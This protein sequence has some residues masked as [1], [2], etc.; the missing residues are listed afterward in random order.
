MKSILD[1]NHLTINLFRS[2][3][4]PKHIGISAI[5]LILGVFY[6]KPVQAQTCV[7]DT[8]ILAS[9][10]PFADCPPGTDT[11]IIQ[12]TFYM[13]TSYEPIF[14][15][16]PFNGIILVDGGVINWN[17]P[18]DFRLG[19]AA[20][21]ILINGGM[22][23][24]AN[25]GDPGCS[26][27]KRLFFGTGPGSFQATC[28]GAPA[29]QAFSDINQ[30]GCISQ[31]GICCNAYIS[32]EETSG[33]DN[34]LTLC[35]PGDSA[36]IQVAGSGSLTYQYLWSPNLGSE[37]GPYDIAPNSTTNYFVNISA[38]FDP[39]V[40]DPY[41]LTC[42]GSV[43][44]R[45]NPQINL[46]A[47]TTSVPCAASETGAIDLMVSGGTSPYTYTWSNGSSTQDLSGL[48]AGTYT[49][50][51]VDARGC[52]E[53]LEV[54]IITIDLSPPILSCPSN[55]LDTALVDL[56]YTTVPGIDA[57]FTDDC[58]SPDLS[59]QLTGATVQ[60][61]SGNVSDVVQFNVGT[62]TVQYNVDD[63]TNVST[64][65]FTVIVRDIQLPTA[66][67][68]ADINDIQCI[69]DV[70][71]PNPAVVLDEADNC[72][73]PTVTFFNQSVIG[74]AG[75][76]GNPFLVIRRYRVTDQSGNTVTVSHTISVA[77]T[78]PPQFSLIPA[79]VTVNCDGI[80]P[81]GS[82]DAMDNCVEVVP[83]VY[84]GET[85]IDGP[86]PYTYT[87][88]RMWTASDN[89]GNTNT[90]VQTITV[91]DIVAPNFTFIPADVTVSCESIPGIGTPTATDNCDPNVNLVYNGEVRTDGACLDSYT[92]SR[93]W[94]ATDACG[95]VQTAV[96]VITV[97]DVSD[98]VFDFVP[99]N[100]T[101]ECDAIP[102]VGTPTATDNCDG[103]VEIT[104]NGEVRTD[105]SCL[106]N[107]T[108]TRTWTATDNCGNTQTASQVITV[109]DT[110][111]PSFLSVPADVTVNCDAIPAVGTATAEDNCD[112]NVSVV[113]NG[114][115]RT[116]GSCINTYTLNRSWTATDACGNQTTVSQNIEVQDTTAPVFTSFP[117]DV[118][119]D[120]DA[121]PG[122]A[123]PSADDNC[124]STVS[125]VY[126]GEFRTDGA[127]S[128][129]YT[130]SRQWTAT[131]ECGN[132]TT[133]VQTITVQDTTAPQF[134]LIPVSITVNCDAV[135]PIGTPTASDNCTASPVIVYNGQVRVDGACPDNYTLT[136]TWTVSD[137][138]GNTATAEQVITV[139]DV[140]NPTFLFVPADLTVNCES[141]PAVGTPI[142]SDNCT[143]NV[144]IEYN[145]ET[146]VDGACEDTYTLV[147]MWTAT[148]A[149]GNFTTAQQI[150]EVLDTISPIFLDIPADVTVSC[151]DIPAVVN[152]NPIDNCDIDVDLVYDGE[153]RVD[154]SCEDSYQLT[155]QWT[156]TDNCGNQNTLQQV[157]TVKD[158][159]A[160]IFLFVPTNI[161]INCDDVPTNG[162][163]QVID[164][165]DVDVTVVFDGEIRIDGD[166]PNNYTLDRIWIATD[167]C[168]NSTTAVQTLTVQ[169]TTPPIFT[170]VPGDTLVNC[171]AVPVAGMP[172]ASDNCTNVVD[173]V[174]DGE[175]RTDGSCPNA[176]TLVR[177]W[178]AT[179]EC[180]NNVSTS[181]L[182]Q[183]QDTTAPV[184]T[185]IAAD[186]L[187]NCD[188]VPD[189]E[190]AMA[191]DNCTSDVVVVY[192]GE[193]RTDGACPNEYTLERSWTAT[194]ECGNTS[195][196]I[197]TISVQDTTLPVFMFVPADILVDCE[198]V[199]TPGTPT[200]SDNCDANVTITYNGEQL[201]TGSCKDNYTLLRSWTATDAC[202]N[203][204]TASQL[205]T[206]QDTTKPVF[207]F[208][209]ADTLVNCDAIP[210]PGMP[211]A[212]DNC[213]DV[214]NILFVGETIAPG[215][216][217]NAYSITRRW[218]AT[219]DCGN[220]SMAQ[221]VL[222]VQDTTLPV[223]T[224]VPVDTLVNCHEIPVVGAPVAVDNC[225][226]DVTIDYLG[227]TRI[228]GACTDSYTLNRSWLATDNCGNTTLAVQVINVQD[229]TAPDFTFVPADTL[230]DCDAVPAPGTPTAGDN[231]DGDVQ[232]VYNGE[233]RTDGACEDAY[234]LTR[235]WTATD[236]CGNSSIATQLITVQDTTAPILL[237][238]PMDT[239]VNCDA[240]PDP[241]MP[242]ATDNCDGDVLVQYL[243][244]LITSGPCDDSYTLS[245]TWSATDNCGNISTAVQVVTVQDTMPPLFTSSPADTLVN[246]DA[247]P[248]VG[249][250][251]ASD[252]CDGDVQIDY[253]GETIMSSMNLETYTL[254]RKWTAT[255][256]CG[257]TSEITQVITVQDTIAP[258]IICP[259]DIA[260]LADAS[261]CAAIV[262]FD[263]PQTDDNC[264]TSLTLISSSLS[265]DTF[266]IGVNEV[267]MQISDPSGNTADCSFYITVQDTTAPVLVNCP[268]DMTFVSPDSNCM[269]VADWEPPLVIDPC[270]DYLI[271][272][273]PDI[274]PMSVFPTGHTVVTYTATDTTGNQLT[275]SFTVTVT[276]TIP[277]VLVDCPV[278]MT[279]YTDTCT[280]VATW[281]P[282]LATDNCDF[283]TLTS[284]FQSGD[285][286]PEGTTTVEYI[287]ADLWGNT[288][289]CTFD[290]TV[291][292]T[293]APT[294]S[295][296]P[297]DTIVDGLGACEIPVFWDQP[298]ATDNCVPD[299]LIYSIP[300][301]GDTFPVGHT[302]VSIFVEDPSGNTDT[303]IFVVTV[304]G[305]DLGFDDTPADQS[306]IGCEA[307]AT[308][309][310]PTPTGICGPYTITSTHEPGDTFPIGVTTVIYTLQDT[311]GYEATTSFTISV[312]E[313]NAPVIDC[314]TAPIV[315][316][317]SGAII[318]DASGFLTATDTV[319]TCDGVEL[320]F[321]LPIATDDC[322]PPVVSQI[323]GIDSGG[324]FVIGPHL[325]E[326]QAIDSAGNTALCPVQIEVLPLYPLAPMVSDTIGCPGD[327]ITLSTPV[328]T[329]AEY[330]WEGPYSDLPDANTILIMGLEDQYTGWYR[331]R[332]LVNG[333]YTPYDSAYV[334]MAIDPEAVDDLDF[335]I[336]PGGL[337]TG[338]DVLVNDTYDWDDFVVTLET[339]I[340]G[341]TDLG[342]GQFEYRAQL[343][344]G[345]VN[346]IYKLCSATCPNLCDR[347]E[348]VIN[349]RETICSYIPN[350]ITPNDDGYNDYLEIPCLETELYPN[351]SIV[352]YNQWGGKVYEASPYSNDP[353][354]AWRGT[355]MGEPGKDLP[356]AT[357]FYIFKSAPDA[358]AL[359]GYIEIFR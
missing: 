247:L 278:D 269:A 336:E 106:Y 126:D 259:D 57:S 262:A 26:P 63:G 325:V 306:F 110:N 89:C 353:G 62:T 263:P 25:V 82:P 107:Y 156:A 323:S 209:P 279:L 121:I 310:P 100:T 54:E 133:A 140:T 308:W 52:S 50:T 70:P 271:V 87:L 266:P 226:G 261:L 17:Q 305:P 224:F 165:C 13:N 104:Y 167:N 267:Y 324:Y 250:P 38:T 351:N 163:P 291:I 5:L 237:N 231:C 330:L 223:F 93:S 30:A 4:Y 228:D 192:N 280:S 358:E 350:I 14:N 60:S 176:Y 341:L 168:G 197:Q 225:D 203:A 159:I 15:G 201:T 284:N 185:F 41:L 246:C 186:T 73:T 99:A 253:N 242:T 129:A 357:Y 320:S 74:G 123:S 274:P 207:T 119:V 204:V 61:G 258:M 200:A 202:G 221:Q 96:Q 53:M 189:P 11:I 115:T 337:L 166:C 326:F 252:N 343:N 29:P 205:V 214:V 49:V 294:F 302:P 286:F 105:G 191:N 10:N 111:N 144:D 42:N 206:V 254:Q 249:M 47:N 65:S 158:T 329:G 217:Q 36:I 315:V 239:L 345:Y 108:L 287:A 265:G 313:N 147:R 150:V 347:A 51:V 316:D 3:F 97:Q 145:G 270:D 339:P 327:D 235:T 234:T 297:Q 33:N 86:C 46:S 43:T 27:I 255:D 334:R 187:V 233:V 314:P 37:P 307:I 236:N 181:Q 211:T 90:A 318:A 72:G 19:D 300:A 8:V 132:Q 292:D 131:D 16:V 35:S 136:R 101:V 130:L 293:V 139:Q 346:F 312:T 77:D 183:V 169:D 157:I 338:I 141:I 272:A 322:H 21:L 282:P 182:I 333:C 45:I 230:V 256:N 296:C 12:D 238:V 142:A 55:V 281:M 241:G 83:I 352:I 321:D 22:V 67:N 227:E 220:T 299:P 18:A 177:S 295:G 219:D 20:R 32:V 251:T 120:C 240:V 23:L 288:S 344:N 161:T 208:I 216:C 317:I 112:P 76:A 215:A 273:V 319:N 122:V 335:E 2:M 171:D 193:T 260:V 81:V 264:A 149:C 173:I 178:T 174:Y 68:P 303:C 127:C 92:L 275:C 48:A 146:R 59:Y 331:V 114:E 248:P 134:I 9:E 152:P 222:T 170:F 137:E 125:I 298:S 257:N 34:D 143:A 190:M 180:G 210:V 245:R 328:I 91:Q 268:T 354:Q 179:D 356:D 88:Q 6:T 66:S 138:C 277:P 283:D 102:G 359:R 113:Y 151:E 172:E 285:I 24:P 98:P 212:T 311:L 148:D 198:A 1:Y 162:V 348:V 7:I 289:N 213:D 355:L 290:I 124:T 301:P 244:E 184:F 103:D 188:A 164:N 196:A 155:R 195:L 58:P 175:I 128:N 40:G 117:A 309:T 232:I 243:G 31:S 39:Y 199:P 194:D 84:N 78:E 64:C 56:C 340:P 135:P 44:V 229:I 276:E 28:S 79:D 332:A 116:D 75:C 349:V 160:P 80:P 154:G 85:R 71:P 342:E 153:T 109:Q 218:T 304:L 94:T 95:N 118:T 69:F